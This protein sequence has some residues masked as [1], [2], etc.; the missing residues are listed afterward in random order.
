MC[1][2]NFEKFLKRFSLLSVSFLTL[3]SVPAL[4]QSDAGYAPPPMFEDM[5]PP[6]VRPEGKDGYLVEPKKSENTPAVQSNAPVPK[7]PGVMPRVSVDPNANPVQAAPTPAPAPAPVVA[8]TAPVVPV[9][10][11]VVEAP[12]PPVMQKPIVEER[13]VP[14]PAPRKVSKPVEKA[15]VPTPKPA[16][17][18]APVPPQ[19][20]V[21]ATPKQE[22]PAP[23]IT[24]QAP[25]VPATPK[26]PVVMDKPQEAA[27]QP[28]PPVAE[29]PVE[30]PV[31]EQVP[32]PP[33]PEQ[34]AEP[35]K[36]V[37]P[38]PR[39]PSVSAIKGPKTMPAMPAGNV[40]QQVTFD[41]APD[42][43]KEETI[44]ERQQNEPKEEATLTPK[45]FVP[46]PKAGVAPAA[47]E[48]GE[49]GALKKTIEYKPGQIGLPDNEVDPVAAGVVR[50]LDKDDKKD[51]RVQIRSYATPNGAGLSSDRRTSLSRALSLRSSLIAQGVSASRIDVLS[52]GS[53]TDGKGPADRIDLYLYGPAEE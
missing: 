31:E 12:K 39:D 4:A 48:R 16:V 40:D 45:P 9:P 20:P 2:M 8:P 10:P 36:P 25:A 34:K 29:K 7:P 41:A 28:L 6:M 52:S 51:W 23:A 3:G 47:F 21:V 5:T 24:T 13:P 37:A 26:E 50:E 33:E 44:L 30:K 27:P 11:P 22:E 15:A 53:D 42:S 32:P 35:A 17:V 43:K 18:P 46:A 1:T 14:K 19:K 49:Q 38:T